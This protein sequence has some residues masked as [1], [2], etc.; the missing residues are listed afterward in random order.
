MGETQRADPYARRAAV[1]IVG[2]GMLAGVVLL[3]VTRWC[4][5]EFE[6]WLRND[7]NGRLRFVAAGMMILTTAPLLGLAAY[8]WHVGRRILRVDRYP[9]PGLRLIQA[10][11]VVTG[12]VA[13]RRGRLLQGF[14][15][16]LGL[17]GLF[18]A[19]LFWRLVVTL[20]ARNAVGW[21]S[22]RVATPCQ[23]VVEIGHDDDGDV[24]MHMSD[25]RNSGGHLTLWWVWMQSRSPFSAVVIAV[26]RPS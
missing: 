13:R 17:A 18:L 24:P 14:A 10:A 11:P 22:A 5:P 25:V 9:P 12:P 23:R 20:P 7:M 26:C 21:S 8:M 19:F 1:A 4:R 3:A 6:T 16:V 2:C 15:I